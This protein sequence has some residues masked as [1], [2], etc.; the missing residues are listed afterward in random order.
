MEY[1][2]LQVERPEPGVVLVTLSHPST[3]NALS[4]EIL[5]EL[6]ALLDALP[7]PEDRVMILTGSGKAFVAGANIAQMSTFT[8]EQAYAF[9]IFGAAVFSKIEQL[10]IPVIAAVNG[11]ALGGGCELA[12]ACDIRLAGQKARF[13]QPEVKLGIT[14]GFSGTYR[15]PRLVGLGRA[16]ELILTGAVYNAQDAWQM[17]LVNNVVPDDQL[18]PESIAL[19]RQI[20][21]NAPIALHQAKKCLNAYPAPSDKEAIRLE[22]K[23][24]SDC[25]ATHDQKMGMTAFLEKTKPVFINQ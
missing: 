10:P 4:R 16:K 23:L 8:P 21:A 13:G 11:F 22:N 20:A 17:G 9:S 18:L 25:F 5:Q 2:F 12:M 15:L 14:P 1:H 19:A 7:G 24:F 3:M 6:D